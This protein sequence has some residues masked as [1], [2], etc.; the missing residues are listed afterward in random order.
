MLMTLD[1]VISGRPKC[2]LEECAFNKTTLV[3]YVKSFFPFVAK[4]FLP[5]RFVENFDKK[6]RK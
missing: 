5:H 3:V 1:N 6:K 4:I 2:A